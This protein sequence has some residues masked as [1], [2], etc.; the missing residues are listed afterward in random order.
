MNTASGPGTVC[1]DAVAGRE[2]YRWKRRLAS[3][4]L[5]AVMSLPANAA[6]DCTGTVDNLSMHLD[7]TGTV[8][9]SLSG[10]PSF[11]Y[12]CTIDGP[13]TNG[14][15]PSVCRSMYSTL[16]LAKAMGKKVLIRFYNH[17]SCAAIPARR[18]MRHPILPAA[19]VLKMRLANVALYPSRQFCRASSWRYACRAAVLLPNNVW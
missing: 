19:H 1:A 4:L 16:V 17:T 14:V 10:G 9:V 15:S 5:V 18:A 3:L 8:T 11:V 13:A 6:V 12:L 2:R 7:S